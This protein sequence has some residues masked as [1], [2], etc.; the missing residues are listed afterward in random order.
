MRDL[1]WSVFVTLTLL[2]GGGFGLKACHDTVRELAL[3]KAAQGLPPLPRFGERY[4]I[5]VD[6]LQNP[7]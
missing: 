2:T 3:E 7:R 4:L 5:S 6:C 1:I